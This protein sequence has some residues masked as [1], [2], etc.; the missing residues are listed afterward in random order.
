MFWC[1]KD[2]VPS[3][4]SRRLC[5]GDALDPVGTPVSRNP[6]GNAEVR[7]GTTINDLA[8]LVTRPLGSARE[9]GSS[10]EAGARRI[11]F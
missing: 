2:D 6:G 11:H 5:C 9:L 8:A 1:F 7:A 3:K 4:S 10:I